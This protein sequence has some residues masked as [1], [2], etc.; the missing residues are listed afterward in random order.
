MTTA[1]MLIASKKTNATNKTS[2]GKAALIA[3]LGLLIMA[4]AAPFAELYVFPQLVIPK[5]AV[6]T[7]QNILANKT[8]FTSAIVGYLIAFL[9]DVLVAWALYILL[10][11][12]DEHLSLLAAWFRLVYTM[13]ALV[14]LLNLVTVSGL[15]SDSNSLAR[16]QPDQLYAQVML[17]LTT[18]RSHWYF[19]LLFFGI[20]LGLLGYLVFR[21]N[22]IPKIMGVLL[23]LA[24]LGYLLTNLKPFL[25][26]DLRLDFAEYT[27]YGELVFMLWLLIKGSRMTQPDEENDRRFI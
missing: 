17:L 21:S 25:F 5:N 27:F 1:E 12:V 16:S 22:Y 13:I 20:H 26:P 11:P 15:L 18:F 10:K 9:C 6:E 23:I 19:G 8:L 2:L 14:A 24:G 3:G 4:I 7:V